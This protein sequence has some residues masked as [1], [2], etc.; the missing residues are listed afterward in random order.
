MSRDENKKQLKFT[1]F[2]LYAWKSCTVKTGKFAQQNAEKLHNGKMYDIIIYEVIAMSLTEKGYKKRLIDNK[3]EEYLKIFGAI[4]IEGPK[5]CGKTWT[6]KN[7]ANSAVFLDDSTNNFDTRTKAQMDVSL[8]LDKDKPQLI[9]EWGQ[10]PEIWDAVRHRCD[11]DKEKGKYILTESTTLRTKEAEEKIHHSGAGRIDRMKMYSM[12]LYESGDSCGAASLKALFDGTQDNVA[13][14]KPSFEKLAEYIV[15]GGWPENVEISGKYCHILPKSYLNAVLN[16]DINKDGVSRDINKMN[17]LFKSLARNESTIASNTT[18]LSDIEEYTSNK[19]YQLSRNTIADYLS[20][21]SKLYLTENQDAYSVNLRSKE[22][23]GK[24]PKRHFTDPSL[25]CAALDI[26]KDKLMNDVRTFGFM[27][28]SLVERDL[29]IYIESLGGKLYHYRNNKNGV[30]VDAIVELPGG[31][32]GAIE[33]KLGANEIEDAKQ[34]LTRFSDE[35]KIDPKFK[36]VICGLWDAVVKDP[37]T[38]IYI[39]PITAL[40]D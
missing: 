34:S 25:A 6:A 27:F 13:V 2:V 16:S 28:E 1:K 12:S 15:R 32:Y 22:V 23:V 39:L 38:G 35:V 31:D 40:K 4:S 19:E 17:M 14:S 18:L 26:T 33:I 5:W 11:K 7:H 21:L 3:I 36:C 30:E 20:V 10:V 37:E 29:R 9:D 8:V 24:S